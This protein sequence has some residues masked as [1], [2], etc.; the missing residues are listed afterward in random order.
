MST[1]VTTYPVPLRVREPVIQNHDVFTT[2][3]PTL[4]GVRRTMTS[5]HSRHRPSQPIWGPGGSR[6]HTC[7]SRTIVPY[8]LT[9][10]WNEDLLTQK[11]DTAFGVHSR[12]SDTS[13]VRST[14]PLPPSP[15]SS[16]WLSLQIRDS[17]HFDVTSGR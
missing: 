4:T 6:H 5:T 8:T 13:H 11:K 7:L 15:T 17:V 14:R 2:V 12:D 3:R 10:H 9:Q 16:P 1:V